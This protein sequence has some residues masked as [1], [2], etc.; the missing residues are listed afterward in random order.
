MIKIFIPN[1]N[2]EERKYII[3]ILLNEFLG[4]DYE[5][6][7]GSKDYEIVLENNKKLIFKD[8]FFNKFSIDLEYLNIENI[9]DNVKFI[10][11]VFLE[12]ENIPVIYGDDTLDITGKS[13]TCGIDIF[14][15]SFF[16]LTRWEEYVNKIRDA[17]NRFPVTESLAFKN[18]F[19]DRPIVNEYI[20]MLKNM[21]VSL[22][23]LLI[24]KEWKYNL[25]LTHDI[26]H[27]SAW[28][29]KK[30]FFLHLA[31]DIVRRKSIKGFF[32][33]IKEY[34]QLKRKNRC[35]PYDTFD[36]I[37][38]LSEKNN[39]V[40]HF[41]FM[42]KGLNNKYDNN[43]SSNS[44]QIKEIIKKIKERG[45]NIGIHPT[46]DTF[47]NSI[48]LKKE[49]DEL[50]KNLNTNIIYG[51]QHFLRFETP[52]T[53]K[54]WDEH[55]MQWESSLNYSIDG[56]RCG[57]CYEYSV[58]DFLSRKKLNLKEKP[59]IFMDANIVELKDTTPLSMLK[60]I[61]KYKTLVKKYNGEFV[62][63]WHNS[64]FNTLKW[65][66]YQNVYEHIITT[67]KKEHQ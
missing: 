5:I 41:F 35:D 66:K 34:T 25:L 30:K 27:I 9:S 36:Y 43:Y 56:F 57:V 54:N 16:M 11:N 50:E 49:I 55:N 18:N 6:N 65:R 13:I 17:H 39:L 32:R 38:N 59:L 48:Q 23:N 8:A 29:T 7:I 15:S 52:L 19:L 37:M 22:D 40:S 28:D 33:S 2:I 44:K 61:E 47:N 12:E 58:F 46:Y 53:W 3:N 26:D 62:L 1:N 64:S 51:R 60:H 42:A 24:F 67:E 4:L 31:R 14:A 10:S 45:H 21:L 63:L 20:E